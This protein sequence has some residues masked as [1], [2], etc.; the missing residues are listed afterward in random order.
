MYVRAYATNSVGTAYGQEVNF[1]TD[2]NQVAVLI[3]GNSSI[4]FG[5]SVTLTASGG[6]SYSWN[7]GQS[8]SS[9]IVTP[10]AT[11]TYTV[12]GTNAYGCLGTASKTVSVNTTITLQLAHSICEGQ[13]YDFYGESLS[14]AGTYTHLLQGGA[15]D[16]L[17]T[18]HLSV[19]ESPVLTIS[20][21]T[22]I[23][24]G[25]S[26]TL[27]VDGADTYLWADGTTEEETTVTT[28]G[29]YGV[30]GY[31]EST[32]CYGIAHVSVSVWQPAATSF[33]VQTANCYDWNGELYCR[34]GVYTQYLETI[35][36]CDSVV[37]L[38][39]IIEENDDVVYD[40]DSVEDDDTVEDNESVEDND[41]EDGENT[42]EGVN[43]NTGNIRDFT[44]YPNPTLGIVNVR[45]ISETNNLKSEIAVFDVYGKLLDIVAVSDNSSL[46]I[47][48]IDLSRCTSGV[49]ILKLVNN[50]EVLAVRKV[51]KR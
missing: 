10:A 7:T 30:F 13:S 12:T 16:T 19:M 45:L 24:E 46:Q 28:A 23:C 48:Q 29:T 42:V 1:T 44:A 35:H 47:A 9:I 33:I 37:T 22:S 32:G 51:V 2:C 8:G 11:T 25:E 39:L 38:Y 34:S 4:D 40:D 26:T 20:G 36:G 21:R 3:V 15:C 6:S 17:I 27:S 49:Y 50:G 14:V 43:E 5:E 31:N 41:E 18:L